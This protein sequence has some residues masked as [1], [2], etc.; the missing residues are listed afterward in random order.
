[1]DQICQEEYLRSKT[2]TL[3]LCVRPLW[4]L[5]ILNFSARGQP[6]KKRY[7]NGQPTKKRYFLLLV[8]ET[9]SDIEVK[10]VVSSLFAYQVQNKC[11]SINF[12][13]F[14]KKH[15]CLIHFWGPFFEDLL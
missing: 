9:M 11:E 7:F 3:S 1:M 5:T 8:A 4:L 14:R 2:E 15:A 6:T 10:V 13:K 12:M